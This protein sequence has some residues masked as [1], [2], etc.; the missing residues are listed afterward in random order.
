VHL[1]VAEAEC[2]IGFAH[3]AERGLHHARVPIFTL[4]GMLAGDRFDPFDDGVRG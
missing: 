1:F 4:M 3:A 2:P